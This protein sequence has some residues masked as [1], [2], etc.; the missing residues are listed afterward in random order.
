M[1]TNEKI[2]RYTYIFKN[3]G[4]FYLFFLLIVIVI[5]LFGKDFVFFI[6]DGVMVAGGLIF[7]TWYL[8][9]HVI[10]SEFG[11]ATKTV[12]GSKSLKWSEINRFSAR[13]SLTRLHH[14]DDNTVLSIGSRLDGYAEIFELLH[15]KRPDL[16]DI[17]K[18][19]SITHNMSNA[20]VQ[21]VIGIFLVILGLLG[22]F[23]GIEALISTLIFGVIF[24]L[25]SFRNWYFSPRT[26]T[27]EQESLNF[28]YVNKTVSLPI[29]EI[30]D[31]KIGRQQQIKSAQVN[32]VLVF[33]RNGHI[34]TLSGYDQSS[35]VMYHLLK[36]WFQSYG[37]EMRNDPT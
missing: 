32:S 11:I 8:T 36:R 23:S 14:Y 13:G 30:K 35:I 1:E 24:S 27:L 7:A 33:L 10:V 2:F 9:T 16:F 5:S 21:L 28:S 31:I 3:L 25:V 29:D 18:Y 4:T 37:T 34:V 12:L 15:Q 26:L 19:K 22:Y 17:E 6:C 20:I